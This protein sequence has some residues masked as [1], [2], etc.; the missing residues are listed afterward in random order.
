MMRM[1]IMMKHWLK[2][3]VIMLLELVLKKCTFILDVVIA[4]LP[5]KKDKC[6]DCIGIFTVIQ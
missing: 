3:S 1:M 5:K 4:F 6:E 2:G